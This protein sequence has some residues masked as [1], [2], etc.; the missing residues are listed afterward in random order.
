MWI[1]ADYV[2]KVRPQLAIFESVQQAFTGGLELMRALR[3]RVETSTGER[4]TLHHVLHNNASV[5]GAAIRRRYFWIVSRIPF[6]IEEP[7]VERV[8]TLWDV[9]GDLE[10]LG[11]TWQAQPYRRPATWWSRTRRSDVGVVDGHWFHET[12]NV[13]RSVD[14]MR[15]VPWGFKETMSVVARRYYA[16]HGK[17]PDSWFNAERI[18]AKD[19]MMGFNQVNRWHPGR[20]ARVITGGGLDVILHPYEERT[21]T[22]RE[23]ARIQGF[24]DDWTIEGIRMIREPGLKQTWG[25]GI[26]VDV[27]RWIGGWIRR[28]LDGNPGPMVGEPHGD[29]EFKIDVTEA[30]RAVCDE[31]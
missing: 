29:R 30:Y 20:V 3:D 7:K 24:P 5:G 26:P 23:V 11:S 16:R 31:R 6:G 25:K 13:R 27:G 19:F 18:I 21:L 4:W 9:I 15:G 2:A 8:P 14:L 22:H 12:P 17:L 1:F 10:G 28:A